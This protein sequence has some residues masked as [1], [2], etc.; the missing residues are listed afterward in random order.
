[1]TEHPQNRALGVPQSGLAF[2]PVGASVKALSLNENN[3]WAFTQAF[4]KT[5]TQFLSP[6]TSQSSPPPPHL[7]PDSHLLL[8]GGHLLG[9]PHGP[10]H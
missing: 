8:L 4:Q 9:I 7:P 1:M 10:N 6:Q 5:V 3:V 2:A